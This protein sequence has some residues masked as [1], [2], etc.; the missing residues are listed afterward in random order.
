[1]QRR[2]CSRI[3]T[4]ESGILR[5]R[6]SLLSKSPCFSDVLWLFTDGGRRQAALPAPVLWCRACSLSGS[7]SCL[8][9]S[10]V[11][12]GPSAPSVRPAAG[13]VVQELALRCFRFQAVLCVADL[14]YRFGP[15]AQ[16]RAPKP[17]SAREA[18]AQAVMDISFC[19]CAC[20]IR[21]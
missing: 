20:A 9:C 1:V 14:Q 13:C 8:C 10:S 21:A 11:R 5:R 7:R 18:L 17:P 16:R 6:R 4:T 15:L 19:C 12:L 3:R 2:P